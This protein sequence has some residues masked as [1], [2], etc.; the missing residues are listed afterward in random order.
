ME[1]SFLK[2]GHSAS[3]STSTPDVSGT[4]VWTRYWLYEGSGE[5]GRR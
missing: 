1:G 2:D 5:K 4:G 3:T